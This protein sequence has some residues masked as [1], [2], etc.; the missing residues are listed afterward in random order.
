VSAGDEVEVELVADTA[1]RTVELP[2]DLAAAL[3]ADPA[4][5]ATYEALPPSHRKEWV[6]WIEEAKRPETRSDRVA[7]TVQKLA[8]GR[9]TN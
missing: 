6:R 5:R 1:S 2:E 8:K 7:K 4:A 3:S 9:R